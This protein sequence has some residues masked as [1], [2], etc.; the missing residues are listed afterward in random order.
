MT[1]ERGLPCLLG[2]PE[3]EGSKPHRAGKQNVFEIPP[4]IEE[5]NNEDPPPIDAVDQPIGRDDELPVGRDLEAF[6]LRNDSPAQRHGF[7]GSRSLH[8]RVE[9]PLRR[10][11]SFPPHVVHD[12]LEVADRDFGPEDLGLGSAHFFWIRERTRAKAS[13]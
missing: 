1:E 12:L 13:S 5:A 6:Q 2:A 9:D 4:A 3:G 7:E 8:D 11:R 10:H